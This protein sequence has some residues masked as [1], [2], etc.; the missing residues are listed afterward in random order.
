MVL[1]TK[2]TYKRLKM[3]TRTKRSLISDKDKR[4]RVVFRDL[5]MILFLNT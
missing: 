1:V 5:I 4:F 2:V 3:V